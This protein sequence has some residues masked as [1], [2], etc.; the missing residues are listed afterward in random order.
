MPQVEPLNRARIALH[1]LNLL[2]L[3]PETPQVFPDM[4]L[5]Y[6][7]LLEKLKDIQKFRN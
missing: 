1:G 4:I 7:W 5:F 3:N 6:L 2:L